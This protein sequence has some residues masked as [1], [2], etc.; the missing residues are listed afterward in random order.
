MQLETEIEGTQ[1]CTLSCVRSSL[2][3][4]LQQAVIEGD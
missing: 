4:H 3:M 1:R 2:E